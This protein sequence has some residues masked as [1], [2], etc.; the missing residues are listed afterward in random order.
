M[1][2]SRRCEFGAPSRNG[3][4]EFH[5]STPV[6]RATR[7]PGSVLA[8]HRQVEEGR[9]SPTADGRRRELSPMASRYPL[10]NTQARTCQRDKSTGPGVRLAPL[11]ARASATNTGSR[12]DEAWGG[13]NGYEDESDSNPE[14]ARK[15]AR[16]DH[17]HVHTHQNKCYSTETHIASICKHTQQ[18][19]I[20]I[21]TQ[22]VM[23]CTDTKG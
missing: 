3:R 2:E 21:D 17:T 5:Y 20:V 12:R 23:V 4:R 9:A 22:K 15:K 19:G 10:R 16:R 11:P 13:A 8:R 18:A 7:R 1:A 6:C 14:R